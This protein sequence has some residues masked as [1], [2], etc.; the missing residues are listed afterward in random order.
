RTPQQNGVANRRNRTLI[1]ATKT[2]DHLGKFDGKADEEFFV[3]YYVV[4]KAMRVINKRTRI[5]EETLNIRFLENTPNVTRFRPDWLFDVDSLTISMNYVPVVAGKQTNGITGTRDYI[6]TGPKNS[7]ED[8]GMKPTE[9]DESG[10]SEKMG[11]MIK[12][13]EVSLKGYVNKKS[14]LYILK[15]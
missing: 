10:A 14:I 12:L 5:V 1:E 3:G 8:F 13:Q 6:V 11:R 7:K 9:V 2:M 4:N 15:H